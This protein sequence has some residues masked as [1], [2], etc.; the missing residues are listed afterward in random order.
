MKRFIFFIAVFGFLYS[1][2]LRFLPLPIIR[3][4]QALGAVLLLSNKKDLKKLIVSKHVISI[5]VMSFIFLLLCFYTELRNTGIEIFIIKPINIFLS[6]FSAYFVYWIGKRAYENIDVNILLRYIVY[7]GVVQTIISIL[8]FMEPSLYDSY[9]SYLNE[10]SLDRFDKFYSMLGRRFVGVDSD[11]FMGSVKFGFPFFILIALPY[12][13]SSTIVKNKMFRWFALTLIII[14]GIFTARTFFITLVFGVLLIF[15]I[16]PKNIYSI[17][18]TNCKILKYLIIT[19]VFLIVL[20]LF[21]NI[22]ELETSL[23]WAFEMFYNLNEGQGLTTSSSSGLLG[24]MYVLPNNLKTWLIGDGYFMDPSGNGYYKSTDAGIMRMIYYFGLPS[25]L[26]VLY[27][28]W[29]FNVVLSRMSKLHAL[30][31]MFS[32]IALWQIT[33]NIKGVVM[34]FEYYVIFLIFLLYDD[35]KTEKV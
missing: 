24:K 18:A 5:L 28:L 9:T 4:W 7:A 20:T 1:I 31:M 32:I 30:R 29:K 11:S 34:N 15:L 35:T 23:R 14:G 10:S 12:I 2:H 33:L 21:I 8:F 3:I 26:F 25:T 17:I 16:S 19:A 27:M 22:S 13:D 6:F